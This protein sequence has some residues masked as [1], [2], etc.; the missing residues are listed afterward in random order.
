MM[1][2][3]GVTV[4]EALLAKRKP[5]TA[6]WLS[7]LSTGLGHIYCGRFTTGLA[8]YFVSLLPAPFAL[9]AALSQNP[10]TVMAGVLLPCLLVVAVYLY[11]I[12]ASYFLAKRIG[13]RYELKD[14]NRGAVYVLFVVGGLVYGATIALFI[15]A[16]VFEA[17]HCP[18]ASMEPTLLKGDRFLVN[19]LSQRST[20]LRGALIIFLAPQDRTVRF[21]KRVIAL[22]GDTVQVQGNEVYVNGRQLPHRPLPATDESLDRAGKRRLVYEDNGTISYRIQE[23]SDG[24]DTAAYPATEVPQGHCFVLGDN[25]E[26]S[27]DSR[28]FGLVP[29][30]DILGKVEFIYLP[31][32][33]WSR[34]GAIGQ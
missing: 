34:F 31:A 9:G 22:P 11:A 15:R 30:G 4:T 7:M 18:T 21:V 14:Y 26:S 1:R 33:D 27:V 29:L 25:R 3:G 12:V 5:A 10:R 19:K 28:R 24:A 13:E 23:A 8:L 2:K 17:Y 20:P 32:R 16:N 6:V